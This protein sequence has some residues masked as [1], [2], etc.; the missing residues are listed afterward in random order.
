M[1]QNPTDEKVKDNS[2]KSGASEI[3]N[4]KKRKKMVSELALNLERAWPTW[5]IEGPR[6]GL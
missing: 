3:T 6:T 4:Q 1:M 5:L 2:Q